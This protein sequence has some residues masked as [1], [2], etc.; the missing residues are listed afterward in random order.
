LGAT[1]VWRTMLVYLVL[2]GLMAVAMAETGCGPLERLM[3]KQQWA[4]VYGEGNHRLD[5]TTAVWRSFFAHEPDSHGI[6][7][8]VHSDNIYS[9]EFRAHMSRVFG[10]ID[11]AVSLLDDPDTLNA[12][13]AHLKG[14]HDERGIAYN[15][16]DSMI[17]ALVEV[18]PAELG[19]CFD[20][21]AW[22]SCM[23]IVID[24]IRGP[25]PEADAA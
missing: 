17:D 15:Y 22:R 23:S 12:Q 2:C 4:E 10:G 24:G 6:F 18:V 5:F 20:Q 19:R 1:S 11:M 13:L 14:Q 16:Y 9:P 3:V 8:R 21:N 7:E 25:A